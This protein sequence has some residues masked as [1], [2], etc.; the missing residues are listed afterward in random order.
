MSQRLILVLFAVGTF[1]AFGALKFFTK[2]TVEHGGI[3][4]GLVLI[5]VLFVIGAIAAPYLDR[6]R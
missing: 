5:G 1:A 2:A 4:A 6:S 3:E